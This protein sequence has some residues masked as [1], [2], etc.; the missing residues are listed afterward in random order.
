M[1]KYQKFLSASATF[2]GLELTDIALIALCLNSSVI[3]DVSAPMA[4]ISTLLLFVLK[5]LFFKH[6]DVKGFFLSFKKPNTQKICKHWEDEY[7]R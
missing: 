1:R 7:E 2:T 3:F 5:K 6:F 4:F